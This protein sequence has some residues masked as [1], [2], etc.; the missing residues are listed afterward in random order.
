MLETRWNELIVTPR[1]IF[2]FVRRLLFAMRNNKLFSYF[3]L[4]LAVSASVGVIVLTSSVRRVI[5][6]YFISI[7]VILCLFCFKSQIKNLLIIVHADEYD[8][9]I[10]NSLVL[11]QNEWNN[12]TIC[13]EKIKWNWIGWQLKSEQKKRGKERK[14]QNGIFHVN[15]A[16]A[17]LFDTWAVCH[18]RCIV[19]FFVFT[20]F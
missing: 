1:N 17:M 11:V 6:T 12:W 9:P 4:G 8:L 20:C 7:P 13:H 14:S 18:Y 5:K 16:R 2:T 19:I 3:F 15:I 10:K